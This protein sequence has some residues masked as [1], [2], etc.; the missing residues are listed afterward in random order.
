MRLGATGAS[1]GVGAAIVDDGGGCSAGS[2]SENPLVSEA[3]RREEWQA[4]AV[5]TGHPEPEPAPDTAA[6]DSRAD[7]RE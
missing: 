3:V 1:C 7:V 6:A 4:P 5:P 2:R